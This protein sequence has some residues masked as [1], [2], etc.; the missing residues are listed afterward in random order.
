MN[1]NNV[2]FLLFGFGFLSIYFFV[3]I[4]QTLNVEVNP[5]VELPTAWPVYSTSEISAANEI[6]PQET[7]V[8]SYDASTES[9][10][11]ELWASAP[12]LNG[13]PARDCFNA[14][15][16]VYSNSSRTSL[17]IVCQIGNEYGIIYTDRGAVVSTE[18]VSLSDVDLYLQG[19]GYYK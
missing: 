5:A 4:F 16:A 14:R 6:V 1:K 19:F 18:V 9:G 8:V 10:N 17:A 2:F 11:S 3:L 13:Y 12:S 7:S 15:T